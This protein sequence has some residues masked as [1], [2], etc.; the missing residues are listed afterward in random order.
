M[1][2]K[3]VGFQLAAFHYPVDYDND[4]VR[5]EVQ[6][7]QSKGW[8]ALQPI[9]LGLRKNETG[10]DTDVILIPMV[11]YDSNLIDV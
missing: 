3:Q 8:E 11:K 7:L 5:S 6:N 1:S 2:R 4:L 10:R 9:H